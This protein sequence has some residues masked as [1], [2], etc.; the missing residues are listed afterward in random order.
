MIN[1]NLSVHLQS[2]SEHSF[3]ITATYKSKDGTGE[4]LLTNFQEMNNSH[5]RTLHGLIN[6]D[7]Q[8]I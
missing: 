5:L 4:P 3:K 2:I 7:F 8:F 6:C 1:Y